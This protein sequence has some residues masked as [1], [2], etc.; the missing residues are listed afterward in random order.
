MGTLTLQ[1]KSGVS[2]VVRCKSVEYAHSNTTGRLVNF[3]C[4]GIQGKESA[5]H[6]DLDSLEALWWIEDEEQ[7]VCVTGVEEL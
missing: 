4:E 1:F 3:R 2:K 7:A 5:I 6:I